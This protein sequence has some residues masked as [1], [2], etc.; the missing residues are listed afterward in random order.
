MN[1]SKNCQITKIALCIIRKLKKKKLSKEKFIQAEE[2][3]LSSINIQVNKY[4]I[5]CVN[6]IYYWIYVQL[7]GD[8]A[9]CEAQDS[10]TNQTTDNEMNGR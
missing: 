5:L 1:L 3:W 10:T 2:S 6:I 7:P 9:L 4:G 8:P